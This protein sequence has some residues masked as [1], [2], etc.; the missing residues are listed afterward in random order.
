MR[1]VNEPVTI[2]SA[3]LTLPIILYCQQVV[4]TAFGQEVQ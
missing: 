3:V 1:L 4:E 2:F